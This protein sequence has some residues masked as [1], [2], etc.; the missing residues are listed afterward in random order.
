MYFAEHRWEYIKTHRDSIV[1]ALAA[2]EATADRH[3]RFNEAGFLAQMSVA[4]LMDI[5][6]RA[7]A[8]EPDGAI[9]LDTGKDG[10]YSF[11]S[12]NWVY[13]VN[14]SEFPEIAY[15]QG[16]HG[17]EIDPETGERDYAPVDPAMIALVHQ[18]AS[19][20]L[21]MYDFSVPQEDE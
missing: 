20:A 13:R 7:V 5:H 15:F 12:S 2:L 17:Y 21:E 11:V 16:H 1:R 19:V 9:H 4:V 14:E 8:W 6:G 18:R 3:E 10:W